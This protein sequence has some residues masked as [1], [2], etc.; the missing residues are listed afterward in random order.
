M[1]KVFIY[2]IILLMISVFSLVGCKSEV[3]KEV[4]VAEKAAVAA[5]IATVDLSTQ[6]LVDSAQVLYSKTLPLVTALETGAIKDDLI[7]RLETVK[8]TISTAKVLLDE[9]AATEA[10]VSAESAIV[11]LSTQELVD[12]VTGLYNAANDLV[13]KLPE[14]AVK[15]DL[16]ARLVVVRDAIGKASGILDGPKIAFASYRD[17]NWEIYIMDADGSNQRRLTENHTDDAWPS[18][19]PDGSKIA[20]ESSRDGNGE[21]YIM[22]ADGSNQRRLTE[23]DAYDM[24][25]CFSP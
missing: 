18:F 22:D 17:G 19:S 24:D 11:D 8:T 21:I 13:A 6:E 20:F 15:V 16:T 23:N 1:K 2:L 12:M 4:E 25:P 3:E 5:E 14:G 7:A 9:V 10:V